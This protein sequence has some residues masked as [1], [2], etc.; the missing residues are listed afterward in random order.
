M[1]A[2][3]LIS[4]AILL[5]ASALPSVAGEPAA[6]TVLKL[7]ESTDNLLK[8]DAW[9]PWQKGFARQDALFVCDNATDA[10]AQ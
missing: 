4:F 6:K 10:T 9:Q 1:H 8:P 2:L 7:G 5:F 3:R